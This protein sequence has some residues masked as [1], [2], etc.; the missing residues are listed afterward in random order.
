MKPL[1]HTNQALTTISSSST[2]TSFIKISLNRD[3]SR[4]KKENVRQL[5]GVP[6]MQSRSK[7]SKTVAPHNFSK[8]R[9]KEMA[10]LAD[11]IMR[12]TVEGEDGKL[13][14]EKLVAYATGSLHS[15]DFQPIPASWP[16]HLINAVEIQRWTAEIIHPFEEPGAVQSSSDY[17]KKVMARV[18]DQAKDGYPNMPSSL[19]QLLVMVDAQL[20]ERCIDMKF[21]K[22][23]FSY[24]RY[25]Y[26]T[27]FMACHVFIPG[28][29]PERL[30]PPQAEAGLSPLDKAL[31]NEAEPYL[32]KFFNAIADHSK[33]WISSATRV[34]LDALTDEPFFTLSSIENE[35]ISL[36]ATEV[37]EAPDKKYLK[38][39]LGNDTNYVKKL[40]TRCVEGFIMEA[41]EVLYA[42]LINKK[43]FLRDLL[44]VYIDN[45]DGG[46]EKLSQNWYQTTR[47][48][49][50]NSKRIN[51]LTDLGRE[52]VRLQLQA[53]FS[54]AKSRGSAHILPFAEIL[55]RA[56]SSLHPIPEGNES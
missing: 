24:L 23:E 46:S 11:E 42:N 6:V 12:T 18:F 40:S 51:A 3:L 7:P 10:G 8:Q 16:E 4:S 48:I 31:I 33:N 2:K 25:C 54:A 45:P 52:Y 36:E 55:K 38:G 17:A 53:R 56:E 15:N 29:R 47:F 37:I 19:K 50:K 9:Q 14:I 27:T 1:V 28:L 20:I 39:V 26:T 44:I 32:G 35:P 41:H 13:N 21:S 5:A 49:K 34:K 43:A 30:R 22:L